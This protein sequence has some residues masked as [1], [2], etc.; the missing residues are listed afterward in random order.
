MTHH[1]TIIR[2]SNIGQFSW[3]FEFRNIGQIFIYF[4]IFFNSEKVFLTVNGL[5]NG[6]KNLRTFLVVRRTFA[7]FLAQFENENA[8]PNLYYS[9]CCRIRDQYPAQHVESRDII[10]MI[11]LILQ[12]HYRVLFFDCMSVGHTVSLDVFKLKSFDGREILG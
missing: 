2:L 4:E 9:P 10:F 7:L 8:H 11:L 1:P 6:N 5:E 12:W 3:K